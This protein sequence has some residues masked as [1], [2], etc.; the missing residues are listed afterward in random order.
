M[1][2][3]LDKNAT[4][5]SGQ[6][7]HA[8]HASLRETSL[9][10]SR[11]LDMFEFSYV[12][13]RGQLG[14]GDVYT[15]ALL[16]C[17]GGHAITDEEVVAACAS[18]RLRHP[19]LG[20]KV[21]FSSPQFPELSFTAPLSEGHALR[22]A[23][24]QIEFHTFED[25]EVAAEAL[26]DLWMSTP[27]DEVLDIRDANCSL[28][29]GKSADPDAGEYV[30][31]LRT[32]HAFTDGRRGLNV[33][34]CFMELLASPG[35]A[36]ME[37]AAHFAGD[38]TVVGMPPAIE[39]LWPKIGLSDEEMA[40]AKV[41]FDEIV[42]YID[43]PFSGLSLE[44]PANADGI[45]AR[46]IRHVWNQEETSHILQTC[47]EQGV[48]ITA[49]VNSA[50]ALASV[51]AVSEPG[52]LLADDAYYF[53]FIQAIDLCSKVPRTS[54]NG[55]VETACHI[56]VYPIIIRVPRAVAHSENISCAV[57]DTARE[58]KARSAEF[59]QSPY[60]WYFL[61]MYLP[62]LGQRYISKLSGTCKPL[63]PLMSS[64][65]ELKTLLP[66]QYPVTHPEVKGN[67]GNRD[68]GRPPAE[69][70]IKDQ[71]TAGRADAQTL[72]FLLCTFDGKL[73]LHLRWNA[74]RLSE[75]RTSKWFKRTV[76]IISG[77]ST[78]VQ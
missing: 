35:R 9:T 44:G 36:R 68:G 63:M 78:D 4:S 60:F 12:R 18:L 38:T 52:N 7:P 53:E 65:G 37:L 3:Q 76:D 1:S 41:A 16:S 29:W 69:I 58:F 51:R 54:T 26:S 77:V 42:K 55:E 74:G 73:Y 75:A 30:F 34:R 20:S 31:G 67:G 2:A 48:T 23:R 33:V 40:K 5:H 15:I 21:T 10:F 25:Q 6:A 62:L 47:K 57:F 39:S 19:L 72:V 71:T 24:A 14:C 11:P 22:T 50:S 28:W 66:S 13:G 27:A 49:L 61:D 56:L 45:V 64:L 70:N 8:P 46:C 59:V 17:T 43:K 32:T